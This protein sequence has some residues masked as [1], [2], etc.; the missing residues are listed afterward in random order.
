MGA[1]NFP[2]VGT[3]NSNPR[4]SRAEQQERENMRKTSTKK[5]KPAPVTAWDFYLSNGDWFAKLSFDS[6]AQVRKL[7]KKCKIS[8]D[9]VYLA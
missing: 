5:A 2:H 4:F 7:F 6:A 1:G 8:G 9:K 3:L